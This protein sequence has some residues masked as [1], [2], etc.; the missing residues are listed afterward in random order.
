MDPRDAS[1]VITVP[2]SLKGTSN[3]LLWS[4]LVKKAIGRLGLWSH[5]TDEAPKPVANEGD[6]GGR[7]LAVVDTKKWVQ[8]D[9]MVLSILQG[10]LELTLLD[11][12]SYCETRKHLW[13][14]LQ[15]TYG[16]VS[17]LS[18]VFEIK[19]AINTLKQSGEEFTKHLSKYR[20]LWSELESLRPS[21]NDLDVIKE[22]KEQD[23]VFGLMLTLDPTYKDVIKHILRSLTLPNMEDVCAQLQKVEG[24]L[25]LFGRKKT[26][27]MAHQAE[28]TKYGGVCE[29]C[30]KSGHRKN[31]CWILHPHLK[32]PKFN[33]DKEGRANLSTET[34]GSGPFEAGLSVQVGESGGK[35]LT[36]YHTAGKNLEP[37]MIR[38]SDID[39]LIKALKESGNKLGNTLG[40]SYAAH[41]MPSI[42]DRHKPL[43]IDSGASHHMI[44]DNHLIK[45]IEPA[46]G[47]VMIARDK[48]PIKGI[49]SL[50]L[51]NKNSKAFYM[52]KFTSN[53]LSVKKCTIDLQC[54]VIF[55]P[56][57]VKF[58]D[59]KIS[60][61]IG[62]GATKGDLYMLEDLSLISSSCFSFIS[63][64][65]MNKNAL[66]HGRLGH[67]H[68][69]ALSI[70][71]PG[72]MFKNDDCEAC[73]LGKHCKTVFQ[74]SSTI[75]ENC[76]DLIHSDV[77]TAPCLSRDDYKYYVT[78]ID[79]K[80]KYTWLT[81]INTKDR[82][83]DAFKKF[84]S[85]VTNHYHAKI[86]IFRFDNGAALILLSRM[87]WLKERI[88]ISW[89]LLG[90]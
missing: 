19:E 57:D 61:L 76:F 14:T 8:E 7:E 31:Q 78:F 54:N 66:W 5:I 75:Y 22:R 29:N 67:P 23:Q 90:L 87:E 77:W 32:P 83:L 13:E 3:Y 20:S 1:K 4:R 84:Q 44:S 60:K 30:K 71:L 59:I 33:R 17:N 6:E 81:L 56:N 73:I 69:R 11:A 79:D 9:L 48:I 26:M 55:S 16:N 52:P 12:Y 37:E 53:L 18:R 85:Y 46:H 25:G 74:R 21:T 36:S 70:M 28:K 64:L 50:K 49:G 51:F 62:Q 35:A 63:V 58:Q 34:S 24:T 82:V 86:K 65:P 80:S 40:Q 2:V 43:I 89:R 41:R 72:V 15:K 88:G 38:R 27:T 10:S 42:C 47:H 45:D 39:A 68:V